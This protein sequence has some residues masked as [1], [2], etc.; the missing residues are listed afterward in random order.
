MSYPKS[1]YEYDYSNVFELTLNMQ[2]ITYHVI[3]NPGNEMVKA[4]IEG[5]AHWKEYEPMY[6][7]SEKLDELLDIDNYIPF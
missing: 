1:Q 6:F 2:G 7:N 3:G 4:R 5:E